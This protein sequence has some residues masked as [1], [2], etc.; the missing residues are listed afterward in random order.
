MSQRDAVYQAVV[1]VKG[2]LAPGE[3]YVLTPQDR[4]K[5][6]IALMEMFSVGD[7]VLIKDM[8]QDQ[9]WGYLSGLISN[10]LRKDTRLN[11]GVKYVPSFKREREA[12]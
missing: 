4:V 10:W 2:V 11:G 1:G 8:T 7:V 9:V 6:R 12:A 5:A 3:A